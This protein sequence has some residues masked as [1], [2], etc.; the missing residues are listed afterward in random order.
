[1]SYRR[2]SELR[3]D[4]GVRLTFAR[5]TVS[6]VLGTRRYRSWSEDRDRVVMR[7]RDELDLGVVVGLELRTSAE[8]REDRVSV[9]GVR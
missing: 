8:G 7:L 4:D 5:S 2:A 1:V 9:R 6:R 3:E